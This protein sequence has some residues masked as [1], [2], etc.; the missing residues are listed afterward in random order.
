MPILSYSNTDLGSQEGG[1]LN[2]IHL[3]PRR[4]RSNSTGGLPRSMQPG[5]MI[6][7]TMPSHKC[8]T[9]DWIFMQGMACVCRE[10]CLFSD[11]PIFTL[12]DPSPCKQWTRGSCS[13]S[14][15]SFLLS[16]LFLYGTVLPLELRAFHSDRLTVL[17]HVIL[18][19][20]YF[21]YQRTKNKI[22]GPWKKYEILKL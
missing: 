20:S 11:F 19:G 5:T 18:T 12:G 21:L 2:R 6:Q 13:I 3:S 9:Q 4:H 14:F 16:D 17:P 1:M 7:A 8:K 15:F 10:I 22:P